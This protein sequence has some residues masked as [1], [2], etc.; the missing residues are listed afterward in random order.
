V[1]VPER[2]S[3]DWRWLCLSAL[4]ETFAATFLLATLA[5]LEMEAMRLEDV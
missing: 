1:S 2:L 5:A 3:A 4:R